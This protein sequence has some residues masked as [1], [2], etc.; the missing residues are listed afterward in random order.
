MRTMFKALWGGLKTHVVALITLIGLGLVATVV[1]TGGVYV[2]SQNNRFC[3][4]CHYMKPYYEQYQGSTHADVKCVACHP[5]RPLTNAVSAIRYITGAYDPRPLAEVASESCLQSGCHDARLLEGEADFVAGKIFEDRIHFDHATH[6]Q[7]L[8]RGKKLQCTSCHSQI[9]QGEHT[10]VTK[11]TCFLCHFKG[12]GEAQAIGGCTNCHGTPSQTVR[13]GGFV[14]S[15]DS[16]LKVGVACQQCHV[17]VTSGAGEVP[18]QRCYSC[19]V[20][21]LE[22]YD[23]TQFI[24]AKHVTEHDVD[25]FKCHE[26]IQHGNVRMIRALESGCENCHKS[27]HQ[28]QREMYIGSGGQ[29]VGDIPSRMFAAQVSCDGCHT[30]AVS[31]GTPEFAETS[32]EA[33][34]QSCVDCHGKNFDLMLD[35]W[36]RE[37][38]RLEKHIEPEVD[39]ATETLRRLERTDA[40]VT[41]A[42]L[43]VEKARH[44]FDFLKFGRGVHNVEYALRLTQATVGYVDQAMSSMVADYRPPARI[45]LLTT[46]DGYCSILCHARLGL[47]EETQFDHLTFP[48]ALHVDDIGV[49]CT[50]CHS[51]EKHKLQ[52]ITRSGCMSCHHEAQDIAC[53]HCHLAQEALYT[54]Q[55]ADWGFDD[56]YPDLMA[57]GEVTCEEC[58]DLSAELSLTA[59]REGCVDCHEEGYDEMLGEWINELQKSLGNAGLRLDESRRGIQA[60]RKRGM[61]TAA[62]EQLH[63]Q[64]EKMIRL[65]E[66]GK[67]AHNHE[68]SLELI[69]SATAKLR[70]AVDLVHEAPASR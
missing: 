3:I 47:P 2:A 34:R 49:E 61:D 56:G 55:V 52:I 67:G 22:R 44:N 11:E 51:P 25:C 28:P 12:V 21:H 36:L 29:G 20:E 17:Q 1:F 26:K 10:A 27:L 70:Q 4:T 14:F 18:R 6:M 19:H 16:Y 65:V 30:R 35:D 63:Q 23:D 57:E 50:V 64:A 32:L 33:Q 53:G 66:Q 68:L 54:G 24:H 5:V 41:A 7:N 43:L 59:I 37:M 46:P 40:D 9:V 42:R 45:P 38:E 58:H 60:A 15:H 31:I 8:R 39:G 13:H 69:G 62:A 48:H